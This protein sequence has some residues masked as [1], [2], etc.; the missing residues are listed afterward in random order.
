MAAELRRRPGGRGR[1][2]PGGGSRH[3]LRL[4]P[5]RLHADL[6]LLPHRHAAP[7]AQPDG[8][9]DRRPGH[10]GARRAAA[11]GRR[12]R[13][14]GCISNIVMMGMGEPL[15]NFDNVAKALRIVMDGEGI[16]ISK[17]RITLSTA[18]VVPMIERCGAE[19]GVNLA[20][21]L[22]AVTD[23]LRDR[24]VPHQP[25]IPDRRADGRLPRLSR[26][27]QRAA[28]HLRIRHAEGRQRQPGRCPR[29]GPAARRRSR[30]RST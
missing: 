6:P 24:I 7:G 1:P 26:P 21:S 15:Y 12:R 29:P 23:E 25:Q 5:G 13:T 20:I 16:S 22:H 28:H 27:Q 11:N 9:R 18:G 3:A 19:L 17:R 10:A 30:P 4:E 2:H 8:G 14:D